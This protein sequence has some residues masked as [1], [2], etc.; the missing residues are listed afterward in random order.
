MMGTSVSVWGGNER[1]DGMDSERG[2]ERGIKNA[3]GTPLFLSVSLS[4]FL[5]RAGPPADA[6]FHYRNWTR[7]RSRHLRPLSAFRSFVLA[8]ARE[9]RAK[10]VRWFFPWFFRTDRQSFLCLGKCAGR[11]CNTKFV[12]YSRMQSK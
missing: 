9:S 6:D 1:T 5:W 10:T 4:L 12:S 8:E 11:W 2:Q 3:R 7:G